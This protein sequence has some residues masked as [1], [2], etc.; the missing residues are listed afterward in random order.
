M[1]A[2]SID[3]L[4]IAFHIG[5]KM[6][7]LPI[8]SIQEITEPVPAVRVPLTHSD[9]SGF[10]SLRGQVLPLIDLA[11]VLHIDFNPFDKA[12]EKYVVCVSSGGRPAALDVHSVGETFTIEPDK[13]IPCDGSD[14]ERKVI[15]SRLKLENGEVLLPDIG[16]LL[17]RTRALNNLTRN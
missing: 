10:I 15:P 7:G 12:D 6:I 14:E 8:N 2:D 11:N 4:M 16:Q 17:E 9:L 1:S 3:K 5:D 13:V